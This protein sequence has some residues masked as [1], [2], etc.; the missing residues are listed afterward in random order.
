MDLTC[1]ALGTTPSSP[2]MMT[3]R[4]AP[5]Q[6]AN[7]S[8][9]D[10]LL[11]SLVHALRTR[12]SPTSI[13]PSLGVMVRRL[14]LQRALQPNVH[15]NQT[16]TPTNVH[17]NQTCT[18]TKRALQP[19][20]HPARSEEAWV[21]RPKFLPEVKEIQLTSTPRLM[22]ATVEWRNGSEELTCEPWLFEV[23]AE[24]PTFGLLAPDFASGKR[25]RAWLARSR[26]C[27]TPC[28]DLAAAPPR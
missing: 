10:S 11:S 5:V 19:F 3:K 15:S 28:V 14:R 13:G 17:S 25:W 20:S 8:R 21:P 26:A 1:G 16:C 27:V 6:F 23:V 22:S 18:P 24:L 9:L 12:A 7:D 4:A 2:T